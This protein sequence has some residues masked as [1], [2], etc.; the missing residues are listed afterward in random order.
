[1]IV[2]PNSPVPRA[3]ASAEPA[4]SPLRASGSATR[5]NVRPGPAPSVR[6]ASSS[7]GI[8]RLERGDRGAE[9]ERRRDE[10]DREHDGRLRER[11]LD[12][13]HVD[14]LAEQAA[15]AEEREQRDPGDGGREHERQLDRRD[16]EVPAPE[17]P[18]GDEVGRGRPDEEHEEVRDEAGLDRDPECVERN[19]ARERFEHLRRRDPQEERRDGEEQEGER[20]C[21][22]ADEDDVERASHGRPKPASSSASWPSGPST[23]S[24]N[25][26]AASGS[27][28]S[29]TIAI[30]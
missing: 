14:R 27:W 25:S 29:V 11:D 28:A 3:H 10:H 4:P 30:G 13:D 5:P 12:P 23:R 7:A 2:A 17:P 20:E 19:V 24:T 1:M 18:H 8:D 21:R 9:V 26:C 6:D 15:P 22:R 16:H